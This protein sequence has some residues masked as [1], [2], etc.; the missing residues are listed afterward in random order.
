MAK[1]KRNVHTHMRVVSEEHTGHVIYDERGEPLLRFGESVRE[2]ERN[3]AD[4]TETVVEHVR[5]PA[6]SILSSSTLTPGRGQIRVGIC[7]MCVRKIRSSRFR[8]SQPTIPL[9]PAAD[10]Q[11]CCKCAANLCPKHFRISQFDGRPRCLRCHRW[12]WFYK[13]VVEPRLFVR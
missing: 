13:I 11:R 10:M 4:I 2:G 7:D 6:G 12:H 9:S 8:R 3:G 5:T 1:K